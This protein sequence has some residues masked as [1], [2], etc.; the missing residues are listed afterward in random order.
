VATFKKFLVYMFGGAILGMVSASLLGLSFIPWYNAPGS[1]AQSMVDSN[2]FARTVIQSFIQGQ[3]IGAGVG[4]V[5]MLVLGIT[6]HRASAKKAA[7]Q[8]ALSSSAGPVGSAVSAK[9]PVK[10]TPAP[11]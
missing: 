3:L 8:G 11:M 1:G 6:L 2:A 7:A 4:A 5:L 9:A 10:D